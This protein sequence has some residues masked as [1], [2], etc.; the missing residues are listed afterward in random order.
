MAL[1]FFVPETGKAG[2]IKSRAGM[3]IAFGTIYWHNVV[4]RQVRRLPLL[5]RSRKTGGN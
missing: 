3:V 2:M 1:L 4:N 5:Y